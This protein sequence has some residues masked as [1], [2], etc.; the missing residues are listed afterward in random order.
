MFTSSSCKICI[1]GHKQV[2][3]S[4]GVNQ[5]AF[6]FSFVVIF[7]AISLVGVALTIV[8]IRHI[9]VEEMKLFKRRFNTT[10]YDS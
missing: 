6:T 8:C 2:C 7:A 4:T 3:Y 1:I 9:L 10:V 5:S